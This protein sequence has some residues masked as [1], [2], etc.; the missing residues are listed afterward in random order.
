MAV[1]SH[2]GDA[3]MWVKFVFGSCPCSEDF[4]SRYSG[5]PPSTKTKISKF[6]FHLATVEVKSHFILHYKSLLLDISTDFI[7]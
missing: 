3:V 6:Q 5:F 4:F 2:Q 7:Q 1:A